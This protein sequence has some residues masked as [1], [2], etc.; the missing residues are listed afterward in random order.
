MNWMWSGMALKH[1]GEVILAGS[2]EPG[3]ARKI[4]FTPAKDFDTAL[5]MAKERVGNGASIAYPF[6]PPTFCADV[7]AI[8]INVFDDQKPFRD[9]VSGLP[10]ASYI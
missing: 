2:K 8:P 5:A 10:K 1:P 3:T 4:G 9:K 6:I 7:G